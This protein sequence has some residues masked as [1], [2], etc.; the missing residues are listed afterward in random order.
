MSHC[1]NAEPTLSI[2]IPAYKVAAYVGTAVASALDQ[3]LRDLE[4]DLRSL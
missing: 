2:V 1:P 4:V 3:T